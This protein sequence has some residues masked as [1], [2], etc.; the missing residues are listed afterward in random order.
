MGFK[1]R[2]AKRLQRV[3]WLPFCFKT[4]GHGSSSGNRKRIKQKRVKTTRERGTVKLTVY[5]IRL[6]IGCVFCK[7]TS[8]DASSIPFGRPF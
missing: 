7:V 1:G 3:F 8:G 4:N 6:P 5:R 2:E